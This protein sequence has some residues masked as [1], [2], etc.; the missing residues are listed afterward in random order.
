MSG[1]SHF[2][3]DPIGPKMVSMAYQT[4]FWPFF[5]TAPLISASIVATAVPQPKRPHASFGIPNNGGVRAMKSQLNI[6][7][8]LMVLV[9]CLLLSVDSRPT[10]A[11]QIT[12][13][14]T[15]NSHLDPG[16]GVCDEIE[17]T[18]REAVAQ[19]NVSLGQDLIRFNLGVTP[20]TILLNQPLPAITDAVILHGDNMSGN[21]RV[22]VSGQNQFRVVDV[23]PG[24]TARLQRLIIANGAAHRPLSDM[25]PAQGGGIRNAGTLYIDDTIL[26]DNSA[27]EGGG[28][29]NSGLLVVK[30]H[31][32]F[33]RNVADDGAGGGQG[34]AIYNV[35]KVSI[36]SSRIGG[37]TPG[38][39]NTAVA[40]GGGLYNAPGSH[41]HVERDAEFAY[42]RAWRGGAIANGSEARVTIYGSSFTGNGGTYG[43]NQQRG[44]AIWNQVGGT[45]SIEHGV[46]NNNA[47]YYHGGSIYNEGT[48]SLKY[49][50]FHA[51]VALDMGGAIFNGGHATIE[52]CLFDNQESWNWGG[53]IANLSVMSIYDSAFTNNYSWDGSVILNWYQLYVSGSTFSDNANDFS[54]VISN[55]GPL[56]VINS[57]FHHNTSENGAAIFNQYHGEVVISNSTFS[58][59]TAYQEGG[60][61]ANWSEG[62]LLVT[63]STFTGNRATGSSWS[64]P[65]GGAIYNESYAKITYSTISEN[66]A[67]I[68][69]GLFNYYSSYHQG[70]L[71]LGGTIVANNTAV[72][73]GGDCGGQVASLDY[74]LDSDGSCAL[75]GNGD[76]TAVPL[77]GSLQ[78]NGGPTQTMA[79]LPGS[80]AIDAIPTNV[81][82]AASDQRGIIRPQDGNGDTILACDLGAFELEP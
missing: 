1:I 50:T 74:N 42:N 31:S 8:L 64:V 67:E 56:T 33:V 54:G 49:S 77:L 25:P 63:N 57:T 39:R 32:L 19:A 76:I 68:G 73:E 9:S 79:L 44:G 81:C 26:Q 23:A 40:A 18:L 36:S 15:V 62:R 13:T 72:I 43:A 55:A 71:E 17:C 53:A 38:D 34:G 3:D 61:I 6:T 35:H 66:S 27:D 30:N 41:L 58:D 51:N 60:A 70:V 75:D 28:V 47:A 11:A 5:F 10:Y 4:L 14:F 80:P 78:F 12:T 69:G 59:N 45:L 7:T 22:T 16:D 65:R 48:L 21:G 2:T 20:L 37:L 52:G 82:L 29:F 24:I 46:F